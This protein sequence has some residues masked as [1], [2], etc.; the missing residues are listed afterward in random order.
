MANKESHDSPIFRELN[1]GMFFAC[2]KQIY[3]KGNIRCLNVGR[4]I[5]T[6]SDDVLL[7]NGRYL[8]PIRM[9]DNTQQS[10]YIY[11]HYFIISILRKFSQ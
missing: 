11:F 1:R 2:V 9:P 8:Q 6:G 4:S 10:N 7:L 3:Q 5:V